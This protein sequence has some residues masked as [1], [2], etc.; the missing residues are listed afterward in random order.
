MGPV[1]FGQRLNAKPTLLVGSRTLKKGREPEAE[2]RSQ[3][4]EVDKVGGLEQACG[5]VAGGG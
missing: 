3:A 2:Q 5:Q 1:D 4:K